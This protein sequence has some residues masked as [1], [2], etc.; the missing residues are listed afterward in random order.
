MKIA[1]GE[2]VAGKF[3]Y[4][5][6]AALMN[7][8][9]YYQKALSATQGANGM[10]DQMNEYYMEGIEGRLNTLQ[11][12]GEQVMSTLFDQDSIEPV[13]EQVTTIVNGL[14]DL[15]DVAGGLIGVLQV[16]S[17]LML[18]T[19]STQI[20][21]TITNIATAIKTVVANSANANQLSTTIGLVGLNNYSQTQQNGS[22][23]GKLASSVAGNYDQLS[24][25]TQEK[26]RDLSKQIVELEEQKN[27]VIKEQEGYFGRIK[28]QA[29]DESVA[30]EE[31][32]AALRVKIK[33]LTQKEK[34]G[35]ATNTEI[36]ELTTYRQQ[37]QELR[38]TSVLYQDIQKQCSKY[39]EI[40]ANGG[41]LTQVQVDKVQQ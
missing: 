30:I 29:I 35:K 26:I 2:K 20:A 18:R 21:G 32:I 24:V 22:V 37:I 15:V 8:P 25:K 36:D 10:M 3:Q 7:N 40:L 6:F 31:S 33:L 5:R 17:A 1:V 27:N 19:F 14:N 34:A 38:K 28:A 12:A 39:M 41:K 9:E 16:L 13:I 23:A 4:N 11:A